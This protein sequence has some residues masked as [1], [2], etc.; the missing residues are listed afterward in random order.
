MTIEGLSYIDQSPIKISFDEK[1]L[2]IASAE[3]PTTDFFVGPGFTDLQV[4]GYG[5]FDYNQLY[6]EP[7]QLSKITQL[8]FAEGVTT[9]L[10]TIITNS[11]EQIKLLIRQVVALRTQDEQACW[12]IEG[13]HIE[14]PFISQ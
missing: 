5:G 4:N 14:G 6:A 1:I 8:L 3:K 2:N 12:S 7:N 10:P 11:V 9:H 13:L